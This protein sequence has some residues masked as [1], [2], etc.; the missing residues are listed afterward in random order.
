MK[1]ILFILF[2]L[3]NLSFAFDLNKFEDRQS[4]LQDVKTMIL[5][6]E[7]IARAYEEYILKN[8]SIPNDTNIGGLIDTLTLKNDIGTT[9]NLDPLN[10]KISYNLKSEIKTADEGIKTLYESN[11]FRKR[12]YYEKN[13]GKIYFLLEDEFAKHLYDLIKQNNG[14]ILNCPTTEG[15]VTKQNCKLNKHIY[16]G[17]TNIKKY[18]VKNSQ[19]NDE[20]IYEPDNYLI[21]YHIDK[22]KTGPIVITTDSSKY[23]LNTFDFI[24]K[25][26]L[27]YDTN[28]L[29]YVKTINGIEVL[30]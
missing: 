5:Y 24:S 29:K 6:E 9:I 14:V 16:I 7:S 26:A 3:I 13:S 1:K 25:G 28:G 21:T 27:I 19:G 8:Y 10:T 20:V 4:V 30:K 11:T 15:N 22:F 12:T 2:L 23:S 18:T 17:V